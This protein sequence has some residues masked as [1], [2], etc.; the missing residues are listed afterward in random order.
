MNSSSL[1]E[2]MGNLRQEYHRQLTATQAAP[3]QTAQTGHSTD[4]AQHRQGTAQTGHSRGWK[5]L[6]TRLRVKDALKI[7]EDPDDVVCQFIDKYQTCEMTTDSAKFQQHK[8]STS[9]NAMVDAA[10]A[11]P[12][13]PVETQSSPGQPCEMTLIRAQSTQKAPKPFRKSKATRT[14]EF[15]NTGPKEKRVSMLMSS[16]VLDTMKGEDED[17]LETSFNDRYA[18]RPSEL[19][20]M[21]LAEFTSTYAVAYG[22]MT[23]DETSTTKQESIQLQKGLALCGREGC[24]PA[25]RKPVQP[26]KKTGLDQALDNLDEFGAPEHAWD[27]LAPGAQQRQAEQEGEGISDNRSIGVEDLH[28]NAD[29]SDDRNQSGADMPDTRS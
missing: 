14:V 9:F 2:L 8:H 13:L 28:H 3:P 26:V 7:V 24:H 27:M 12:A 25:Q 4:R 21:S 17:I 23:T 29:L 22:E 18:A 16:A 10:S 5:M 15:I 1:E 6:R 20:P 19:E 11:I